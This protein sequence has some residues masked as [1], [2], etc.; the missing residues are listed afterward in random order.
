MSSSISIIVA[1][2]LTVHATPGNLITIESVMISCLRK[3]VTISFLARIDLNPD[4]AGCAHWMILL[5]VNGT[6]HS[7]KSLC[8]CNCQGMDE[9]MPIQESLGDSL[10]KS[11]SFRAKIL[12]LE[13][14]TRMHLQLHSQNV[15]IPSNSVSMHMRCT[16]GDPDEVVGVDRPTLPPESKTSSPSIIWSANPDAWMTSHL[17]IYHS[18]VRSAMRLNLPQPP[19]PPPGA[20]PTPPP[21]DFPVFVMNLA[22]RADKRRSTA[23]LLRSLG[24]ARAVFPDAT[25]ASSIDPDALVE[26]GLVRRAAVDAILARK[27]K[28]PPALRPY[29]ANA[30]DQVA[31]PPRGAAPSAR[32]RRRASELD[33]T[34][35]AQPI[36]RAPPLR[37]SSSTCPIRAVRATAWAPVHTRGC[38]CSRIRANPCPPFSER[39]PCPAPSDPPSGSRARARPASS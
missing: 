21:F 39:L 8:G 32:R 28:G 36:R 34:V 26:R 29:L 9:E 38:V 18:A 37:S 15:T 31:P 17:S 20:P 13:Y 1:L 19:P 33:R 6:F 4:W 3:Q 27:D 12:T 16:E 11:C 14:K 10:V 5:N 7:K 30:L 25:P 23:A 35:R 2:C 24:F 22:H